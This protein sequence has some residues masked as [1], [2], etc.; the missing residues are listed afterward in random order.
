MVG[1]LYVKYRIDLSQRN[2]KMAQIES[3]IKLTADEV[4]S[5]SLQEAQDIH[6][7]LLID[8]GMG[9]YIIA[10]RYSGRTIFEYLDLKCPDCDK[11]VCTFRDRDGPPAP[12]GFKTVGS[13]M[14]SEE[15]YARN[16]E[17]RAKKKR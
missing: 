14:I 7:R 12:P 17:S 13:T 9:R 3:A 4:R 16:E 2:K 11:V 5:A 15:D 10:D 6:R 1:F 8:K